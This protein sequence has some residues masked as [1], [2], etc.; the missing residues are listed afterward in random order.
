[1][2]FAVELTL[3]NPG[4]EPRQVRVPKGMLF[5][6]QD[7]QLHVQNLVSARDYE[8]ALDPY[9]TITVVVDAYCANKSLAPPSLTPMNV[10]P[11]VMLADPTSQQ[12]V[13]QFFSP[14]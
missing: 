6:V 8:F 11:F 3:E 4:P 2:G 1:V 13:W 10:T 9:S 14:R 7:P 5:E 12:D